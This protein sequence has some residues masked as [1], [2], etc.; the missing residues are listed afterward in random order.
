MGLRTPQPFVG[1]AMFPH[2]LSLPSAQSDN[3]VSDTALLEGRQYRQTLFKLKRMAVTA[4]YGHAIPCGPAPA[5]C[6][7]MIYVAGGP[8]V[9]P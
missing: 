3:G 4:S 1:L 7:V 8:E 9:M 5:S 6:Q 2:T